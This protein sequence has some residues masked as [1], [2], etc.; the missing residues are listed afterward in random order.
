M[1]ASFALMGIAA[2]CFHTPL[3]SMNMSEIKILICHLVK[4]VDI[5]DHFIVCFPACH[6]A[7]HRHCYWVI[8]SFKESLRAC[9]GRNK[10]V[11]QFD[12]WIFPSLSFVL[13][14]FYCSGFWV[15]IRSSQVKSRQVI[16][17]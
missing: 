7:Q 6:H 13:V 10:N 12:E 3:K 1:Y 8:L 11:T 15:P 5:F 17:I 2:V 4:L 14:H 16:F 9:C